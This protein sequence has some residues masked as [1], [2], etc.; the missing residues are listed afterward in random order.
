[1]PTLRCRDLRRAVL[2]TPLALAA[3]ALATGPAPAPAAGSFAV[4][5]A[6]ALAAGDVAL[7]ALA[8]STPL[9]LSVTLAPR[10]PA[11]LAALATAVSTP[12]T[13]SYHRYLS[14]AQFAA[15]FGAA[16]STVA[17][18]RASLRAQGLTP[19]AL[20][21]DG[22][23][24]SVASDAGSAARAF[25]VGL[26]RFR[27]A[28]GRTVFAND[29]APRLPAALRGAVTG[30]LGLDDLPA[31][32]PTSLLTSPR[33]QAPRR[34]TL[35]PATSGVPTP[36]SQ[37]STA[38]TTHGAYTI[39]RIAHAY[40]ID[41]L[42]NAGDLGAGQTVAL[43]E[44][45]T[46][47]SA[48]V[49]AY[50]SCFGTSATV[51]TITVGA[52]P[53]SSQG[54]T[55]PGLESELDIE[56]V[57]GLAPASTIDV[58]QGQNS[59]SGIIATFQQ[60]VGDDTAKVISDS[61]G[62]C[63]PDT[64]PS[65]AAQEDV[66]FR[67]AA[68]QGQS[69]LVASGDSGSEGCT[70]SS[71]LAVV[72]PASQPWAT[73]V[74]GTSLSAAGPPPVQSAWRSGGGGISSLATMPAYQAGPGVLSSWSSGAPC[75]AA[76]GSYCREVPDVSADASPSTGYVV[77]YSG[78][79]SPWG[80]VGGTSAAAPVWAAIATL[81]NASG[82]G[83][84]AAAPLGFLNT[85]LYSIAA[86]SGAATALSDVTSGDNNPS[87]SGAYPAAANYDMASGLGTPIVTDG[88]SPGLVAQLCATGPGSVPPLAP[89]VGAISPAEA[90]PGT[91]VSVTGSGFASGDSVAFGAVAANAVSVAS[92]T[93]LT[94][95]VPAGSGAVDV[96]V[97]GPGGTSASGAADVFTYAP[98]A[99]IAAP[100]AGYAC[101]ASTGVSPSCAAAVPVGAPIDTAAPGVHQLTVTA[102]D[103]NGVSAS[104]TASYTVVPAP[105]ATIAVPASGATYVAGRRV[106]AS[107]TCSATAPVALASCSGPVASGA[108]LDTAHPGS[109]RFT[110]LATDA[111]A[112]AASATVHYTV[113]AARPALRALRE[114]AP[115]WVERRASGAHPTAFS[116]TLDQA[117]RVTLRFARMASGRAHAAGRLS[118]AA[119]SGT[120]RIAFGGRTSAGWLA[121]GAYRVRVT[122]R[123][124]GGVP[125]AAAKLR[126]T[127]RR[128]RR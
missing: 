32:A 90:A 79:G 18:V 123:G 70:G 84:C 92:A 94:A 108:A 113:V 120:N 111:N 53:G 16:P 25:G 67:E 43:F 15:R 127:V 6:P 65:L 59:Y 93:D 121:P 22:L 80:S 49:G 56:N 61:W 4:G 107:Y 23:A 75:G 126:F 10:D 9:S 2:A 78:F 82:E 36:C 54:E 60:I 58:Y 44:L 125:S 38:G 103:S 27:D 105:V 28:G 31:A 110:V 50:Q 8:A 119:A 57:I 66:L 118:V 128:A 20:A 122:A 85:A 24:L 19:G 106:D 3:L 35:A 96:T 95:T 116:F 81:A 46:Y 40:G 13:P 74:G 77:Y 99:A 52:G 55:D 37:A 29:A 112:I 88:S 69:I 62:A 83:D 51:N 7:G 124:A 98:T 48:D 72:D 14:V 33:G 86:G 39:D 12:G 5:A 47:T 73:A 91:S 100:A 87:G 63:E 34:S 21:A 64:D 102:T 104:Q 115:V 30:V 71:Q 42:W 41:G 101:A 76:A 26:H 45:E 114:S 117:A 68:V 11:G 89:S 17:A 97:A 109:H 1:M